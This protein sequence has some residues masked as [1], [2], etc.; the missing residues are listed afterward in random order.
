MRSSLGKNP[1]VDTSFLPDEEREAAFEAE[2]NAL[3][4]E[5]K[6]EQEKIKSKRMD[7]VY[8]YWDGSGH[9]RSTNVPNGWTSRIQSADRIGPGSVWS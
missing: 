6:A 7:V 1:T 5:Y 9:R 2:R 8:S 4:D 3:I